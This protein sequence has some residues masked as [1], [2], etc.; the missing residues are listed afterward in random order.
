MNRRTEAA[1]KGE[2]FF[3]SAK[4]CK[5]DGTTERYT[6]SGACVVC[7]KKLAADRY[8]MFR[9]LLAASR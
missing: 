3:H 4:P 5:K 8:R 9:D 7:N 6:T 1:T 2:R